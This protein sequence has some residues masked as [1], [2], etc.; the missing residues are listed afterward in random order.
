M[1]VANIPLRPVKTGILLPLLCCLLILLPFFAVLFGLTGWSTAATGDTPRPIN[2]GVLARRGSAACLQ[3]WSASAQ[4]L[5]D[6]LLGMPMQSA[7][8]KAAG[9]AG[10]TVPFD[11]ASVEACMRELRV[12]IYKDYGKITLA[13]L[14]TDYRLQVLS[15]IVALAV[16]AGLLLHSRQL[17]RRFRRSEATL[18]AETR[19]R[20]RAN[21]ELAE[22]N[23]FL[24][25]SRQQLADIIDFLPDATFVINNDKVVIAWN[26]AMEK[27]SGVKKED[28][29][30][31][32]DYAYAVPFYGERRK[33]L[34][35][36]LDIDDEE[37]RKAYLQVSR[38]D[39]ILSAEAFAPIL[40]G[41]RGAYFRA[42]GA[43]LFDLLGRRVGA[44][45][46]IRD[47]TEQK[48]GE[49]ERDRLKSQLLQA[50]KM[51]AIGSLA[52]GI[53]HDFNNILGA[54]LGY[55]EMVRDDSPPGSSIAGDIEQVIKAGLRASELVKQILTF[56]RQDNAKRIA[57]QPAAIISE[58]VKLLRPSLP[59]TIDIRQDVDPRAGP[60]LAD[61]SQLHQILVNL[62]TNAY[63][64]MEETGG[65]L[66]ISL[67]KTEFSAEDLIRGPQIKPGE[68]VQLSVSDT[69]PGM[70]P[71]LRA[72][73][74]EP[75]FTTKEPGKG[76]GMGLAIVHGIVMSYG[77][78]ITCYS[79][80]GEGTVFHVFLPVVAGEILAEAKTV[81]PIPV[82]SEH[83]LFIDDEEILGEM[84]RTMLE[85]LGY[86][87]TVKNNSL[88]A[89]AT[90][91]NQPD[92]YDLVITDQTMPGMTGI[93]LS[94]RLL[95]IRPDLP[96]ILCT[97][98]SN[99]VSKEQA[100]VL[101]IREFAL[102]PLAKKDIAQLIRKVLD[103]G[104]SIL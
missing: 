77:G 34:L 13:L 40:N 55:A 82:G 56:S 101:G 24:Q 27:M 51:E 98:F 18:L 96:I 90:F 70:S 49:A 93:D 73:I 9:S 80:P 10:W 20:R 97:G 23:D 95:Q 63:H 4:Y 74:F 28:M 69:G 31:Q 52:G 43:P 7:A 57:L 102:K 72:R 11:Y 62:C 59:S 89:L 8:A 76:T 75:Y 65:I 21:D 46:S 1:N 44:I 67:K 19:E 79:Q 29:I 16:L 91:Q 66:G 22:T 5:S 71:E 78:Y 84:A 32:G 103:S 100:R 26:R 41:G 104:C 68:F 53:A 58:A 83:I 12:G 6:R 60:V 25:Q 14:L 2:I 64:A 36:L 42:T 94:Q 50:Q 48:Q 61:P 35:D 37:L 39:R 88:D 3:E 86:T 45:E 17:N 81:E 30:G 92:R 99:L 87:V 47:I 15:V 33:Q 54:L 38:K 85:R